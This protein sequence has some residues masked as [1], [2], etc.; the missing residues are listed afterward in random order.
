MDFIIP[1]IL[2]AFIFGCVFGS[3]LCVLIDRLP[4]EVSVTRG[5][6][7][8]ESCKH[9]LSALDLIPVISYITLGGKCRYCKKRIPPHVFIIEFLGGVLLAAF[10]YYSVLHS[11][12]FLQ[13][14]LLSIIFF[15]LA[16]LLFTDIETGIIPDEFTI[17]IGASSLLLVILNPSQLL[18]YFLSAI[19][20]FI[21]F[22]V[23]FFITSGRGMGFGDVK[24]SFAIGLFLGFP[25]TIVCFYFAFLT[26]TFVS[27]ILILTGRKKLR[28]DT[29][30]FGPYIA[31]GA[32]FAYFF[33]ASIVTQLFK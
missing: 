14:A 9:E 21:F 22:F 18:P 20:A 16:G 33:G 28:G 8:C 2:F 19:G 3:F 25:Q 24:L 4:Q 5:R 31:V 1:I 27:I 13:F 26:A 6:S 30:A 32:G 12:G 7:K 10:S 15:S 17:A 23:L 11:I 29:I